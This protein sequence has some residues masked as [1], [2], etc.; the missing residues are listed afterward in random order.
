MALHPETLPWCESHWYCGSMTVK[1]LWVMQHV[2]ILLNVSIGNMFTASWFAKTC[3]NRL[4]LKTKHRAEFCTLWVRV[5][6]T[7]KSICRIVINHQNYRW[8]HY[9]RIKLCGF[10]NNNDYKHILCFFYNLKHRKKSI[11]Q[12]RRDCW[13][14]K[15]FLFFL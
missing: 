2:D 14:S 3:S 13:R 10:W 5:V 7:G 12:S 4:K 11:T 8:L 6:P 9:T 15:L 1:T